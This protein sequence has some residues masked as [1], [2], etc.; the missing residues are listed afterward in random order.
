MTLNKTSKRL[1]TKHYA[2]ILNLLRCENK[3]YMQIHF[4]ALFVTEQAVVWPSYAQPSPHVLFPPI[5]PPPLQLLSSSSSDYL[6]TST[7]LQQH[8]QTHHSTRLVAVT[9]DTKRKIPLPIPATTVIKIETDPAGLDQQ[10]TKTLQSIGTLA[11][12]A[13]PV[14]SEQNMTTPLV[15]THVIYQHPTNLIFSSQTQTTETTSSAASCRSQGT[16]PVTCLTPPPETIILPNHNEEEPL[17]A[18][19]TASLG[20]QDASNQTETPACSSSEEDENNISEKKLTSDTSSKSISSTPQ[21]V[22]EKLNVCTNLTEST[23]ETVAR[24]EVTVTESN[25][26][27]NS[28]PDLSGLELLSNSIVEHEMNYNNNGM[29]MEDETENDTKEKETLIELKPEE[30]KNTVDV[31]EVSSTSTSSTTPQPD[32]DN[33][34]YNNCNL[35]GLDLLCALAEQRIKEEGRDK[36]KPNEPIEKKRKFIESKETNEVKS[37]K[38]KSNEVL[39]KVRTDDESS[40]KIKTEIDT[41]TNERAE[42]KNLKKKIKIEHRRRNRS[43]NDK[44]V[45]IVVTV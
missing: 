43:A 9:T 7:T 28:K 27:E 32:N 18:S 40:I 1:F 13:G 45:G 24:K 17:T 25:K 10:Q 20:V 5:P 41:E 36:K 23:E 11:N 37:K 21:P 34:S 38:P 16:S 31:P 19:H 22:I 4:P 29:D 35:G 39:E 12:N 8:T 42:M 33:N 3:N 15:T 14:F 26:Q 44:Q 6:A 30:T 2:Y